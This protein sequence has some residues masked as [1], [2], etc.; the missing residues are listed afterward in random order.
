MLFERDDAARIPKE[1]IEARKMLQEKLHKS[2]LLGYL[3]LVDP[4]RVFAD[5]G[6]T[7]TAE[8]RKYIRRRNPGFP[9]GNRKLYKAVKAGKIRM[10][11]ITSV[12]FRLEPDNKR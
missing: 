4:V 10:P 3:L 7:L 9:Y 12:K 2:K 6:I 1:L 5:A 8:T 11:W